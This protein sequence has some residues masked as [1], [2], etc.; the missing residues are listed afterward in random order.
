MEAL[1]SMAGPAA[2]SM[3]QAT[4]FMSAREPSSSEPLMIELQN[5]RYVRVKGS[6]A[7]GEAAPISLSKDSG[8]ALP[9]VVAA[10][11]SPVLP[12]AVLIFH[13]GHREEV[14]DYSI[15]DGALYAR[16]DFYTHRYSHKKIHLEDL[17]V[18]HTQRAHL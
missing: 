4:N 14:R 5:G 15:A 18:A 7:D 1:R 2:N 12:A 17:D 8:A 3:G 9:R 11:T 13:D 6:A 10:T 16:G